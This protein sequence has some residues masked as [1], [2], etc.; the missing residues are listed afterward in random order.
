MVH[1]SSIFYP[2]E[3]KQK[4]SDL[5]DEGKLRR[6][7]LFLLDIWAALCFL[8]FLFVLL[9]KTDALWL[10]TWD[11]GVY[12]QGMFQFERRVNWALTW[13][14]SFLIAAVFYG[15][16]MW[17]IKHRVLLYTCGYVLK[18]D[19]LS[20]IRAFAA[21]LG[22]WYFRY[23]FLDPA[24]RHYREYSSTGKSGFF[25]IRR[26][27]LHPADFSDNKLHV[28]VI[29]DRPFIHFPYLP[30]YEDLYRLTTDRLDLENNAS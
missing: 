28:L 1:L 22:G 26:K 27:H 13:G 25:L 5:R 3:L 20:P 4:I 30:A 24:V 19:L 10:N 16:L 6:K 29:P 7:P 23:G 18:A 8:P 12:R 2:K 15:V 14:L 21:G 11:S 9:T 17:K